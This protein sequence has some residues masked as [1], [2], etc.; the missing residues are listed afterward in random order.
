MKARYCGNMWNSV[1]TT[2]ATG[3]TYRML[4]E[5][6]TIRSSQ[7]SIKQLVARLSS[8]TRQARRLTLPRSRA[9]EQQKKISFLESEK[10]DLTQLPG[11]PRGLQYKDRSQL[12]CHCETTASEPTREL[13]LDRAHH[14]LTS[15]SSRTP[16]NRS[17]G[18]LLDRSLPREFHSQYPHCS[19]V[20]EIPADRGTGSYIWTTSLY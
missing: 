3:K 16:R 12:R 6:D 4:V 11:S 2:H 9:V 7:E 5:G 15:A 13:Q 18:R 10:G 1:W 14:T 20:S 17:S 8:L 19:N